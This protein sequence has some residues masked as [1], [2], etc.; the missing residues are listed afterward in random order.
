[1]IDDGWFATNYMMGYMRVLGRSVVAFWA[2]YLGI[3]MVLLGLMML[4]LGKGIGQMDDAR[5]M[6]MSSI[7]LT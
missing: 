2:C 6:T 1:L 3:S 4:G 7:A 5:L